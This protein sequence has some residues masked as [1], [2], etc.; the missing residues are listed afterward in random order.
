[1]LLDAAPR[2]AAT[3]AAW[4]LVEQ[5]AP[6]GGAEAAALDLART[7]AAGAPLAARWHKRALAAP[8]PPDEAGALAC[9]ASA[10]FAE[11]IA[12]FHAKR[13]PAFTGR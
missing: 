4:G 7:I 6:D 10:D 12:A 2:D 9:F 11:G 3:A 5:L 13:P 8:G 1:M